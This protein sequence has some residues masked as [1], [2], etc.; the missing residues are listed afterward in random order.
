MLPEVPLEVFGS[1]SYET[2]PVTWVEAE[3]IAVCRRNFDNPCFL[4]AT[5]S[6]CDLTHDFRFLALRDNFDAAG[7]S[8]EFTSASESLSDYIATTNWNV[9]T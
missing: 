6:V 4:V 8:V 7:V 1:V 3:A 2:L 5:T 9:L